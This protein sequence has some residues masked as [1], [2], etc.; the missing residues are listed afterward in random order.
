MGCKQECWYCSPNIA[1]IAVP[2]KNLSTSL[3]KINQIYWISD[4]KPP[5][6]VAVFET[7]FGNV[8]SIIANCLNFV[9]FLTTTR[10]L[11]FLKYFPH[12]LAWNLKFP[13]LICL[14][15]KRPFFLGPTHNLYKV[16]K[17][18]QLNCHLKSN[19]LNLKVSVKN[20][21]FIGVVY[22]N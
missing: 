13:T 16:L 9:N 3:Q 10:K 12:L 17:V 15:C 19:F 2:L 21:L 1:S 20:R 11:S 8:K 6:S 5:N 18:M 22:I 4:R 7:V 14:I